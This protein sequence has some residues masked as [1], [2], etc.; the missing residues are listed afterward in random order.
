MQKSREFA[1][2]TST[3][4]LWAA[5]VVVPGVQLQSDGMHS[6][7]LQ[8]FSGTFPDVKI[9]ITPIILVQFKKIKS[10]HRQ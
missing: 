4:S 2:P 7:Q 5:S 6:V 8:C 3:P 10:R 9:E 1:V